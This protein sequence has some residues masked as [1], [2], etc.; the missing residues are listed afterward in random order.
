M[1]HGV[2][3]AVLKCDFA[4]TA[5]SVFPVMERQDTVSFRD[6]MKLGGIH[7]GV[8]LL[9]NLNHVSGIFLVLGH[10]EPTLTLSSS[11][12][13]LAQRLA[14]GPNATLSA[15]AGSDWLYF[16]QPIDI[17]PTQPISLY[18]MCSVA[19]RLSQVDASVTLHVRK[20]A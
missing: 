9:A 8:S 6:W 11:L 12:S 19:A 1:R 7:F 3:L 16:P 20:A 13:I 15:G 4:G 2:E 5:T 17:K 10:N 14:V 18:A